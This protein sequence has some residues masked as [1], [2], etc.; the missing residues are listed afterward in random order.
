MAKAGPVRAPAGPSVPSTTICATPGG[1]STA[2][3]SATGD[4]AGATCRKP[5]LRC[6]AQNA[7]R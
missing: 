3:A 2:R 7:L 6:W 4:Q 5:A 1:V